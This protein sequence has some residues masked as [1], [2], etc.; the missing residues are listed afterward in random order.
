MVIRY[1]CRKGTGQEEEEM[2]ETCEKNAT[3]DPAET[4]TASMIDCIF[5]ESASL[6]E[7]EA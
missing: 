2:S 3:S 1:T 5:E 7:K 6:L 4:L